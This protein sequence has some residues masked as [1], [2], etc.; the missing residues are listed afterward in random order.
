[1]LRCKTIGDFEQVGQTVYCRQLR[2]GIVDDANFN[3]G[4]Q[5]HLSILP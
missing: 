1:M 2:A 5:S 4:V 3:G